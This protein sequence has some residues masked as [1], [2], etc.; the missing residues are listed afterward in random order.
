MN[1]AELSSHVAA[2]TSMP[3]AAAEVGECPRSDRRLD[4]RNRYLGFASR[5]CPVPMRRVPSPWQASGRRSV[6]ERPLRHDG[7]R[8]AV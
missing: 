8:R 2:E 3:G 6:S 4:L 1:K 5:S 7:D